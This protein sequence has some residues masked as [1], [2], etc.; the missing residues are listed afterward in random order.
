MRV[1]REKFPV[2]SSA[3]QARNYSLGIVGLLFVL[4]CSSLGASQETRVAVVD[5]DVKVD[6]EVWAQLE[7]NERITLVVVLVEPTHPAN[8]EASRESIRRSQNRVLDRVGA[9]FEL[10]GVDVLGR[11]DGGL[12]VF[13][14]QPEEFG[15]VG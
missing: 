9:G 2:E 7:E 4:L 11:L 10:I 15:S 13:D 5:S 1:Q 3:P 8:S 6:P 12:A 14:G